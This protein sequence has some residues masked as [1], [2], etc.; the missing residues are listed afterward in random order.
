MKNLAVQ[1]LAPPLMAATSET[2]VVPLTYVPLG[3]LREVVKPG[4]LAQHCA[5]PASEQSR[6]VCTAKFTPRERFENAVRQRAAR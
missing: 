6:S 2:P 3:D 4:E 5:R 1:A